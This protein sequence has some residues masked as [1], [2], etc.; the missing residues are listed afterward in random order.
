MPNNIRLSVRNILVPQMA[1]NL[2]QCSTAFEQPTRAC[3][4]EWYWVDDKDDAKVF[5]AES[6]VSSF[7]VRRRGEFWYGAKVVRK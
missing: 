6:I 5:H 3:M 7:L 4:F 1:L 2:D